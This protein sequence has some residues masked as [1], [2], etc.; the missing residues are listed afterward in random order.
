MFKVGEVMGMCGSSSD[1]DNKV[2]M[3]IGETN[4]CT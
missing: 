3:M 1:S 2:G 4:Y